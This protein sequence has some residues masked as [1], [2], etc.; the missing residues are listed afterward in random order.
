MLSQLSGH[1]L[2]TFRWVKYSGTRIVS[3]GWRTSIELPPTQPSGP[4]TR[5]YGCV[6][7]NGTHFYGYF[8]VTR[9]GEIEDVELGPF[10]SEQQARREVE[11]G[12][13]MQY[14]D[15]M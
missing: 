8:E 11:T 14:P 12:L 9:P 15:A 1:R 10:E 7:A 3:A 13:Q 6:W 4:T 5:R 2:M